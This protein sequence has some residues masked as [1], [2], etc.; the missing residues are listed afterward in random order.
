MDN[1]KARV[2]HLDGWLQKLLEEVEAVMYERGEKYGPGNIAQ[3]GELGILVRL[4]DKL[5]R[6]QGMQGKDFAD[7]SIRDTWM[8]VI[9]YGLIGLSWV[10]GKWPGSEQ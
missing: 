10:D 1:R 8:D 2:E 4:S 3:F 5:S 6:L 7:E 9:G